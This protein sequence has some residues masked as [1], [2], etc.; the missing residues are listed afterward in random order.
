MFFIT[1]FLIQSVVAQELEK[2]LLWKI[3]RND[4][5]TKES[6]LYGTMHI[7]CDT[8]FT[9]STYNALRA[10]NYLYLEIADDQEN[11][12]KNMMR[13]F[14]SCIMKDDKKLSS[15]LDKADYKILDSLVQDK[16]N[17][18]VSFLDKM[19]PAV[20]SVILEG[21]DEFID[22]PYSVETVLTNIANSQNKEVLGLET[23]D[24]Q[25]NFFI[26]IP[27]DEQ[28]KSLESFIHQ[29]GT[30]EDVDLNAIYKAQDVEQMAKLTYE[31]S[32]GYVENLLIKRN[33]NWLTKIKE[34]TNTSS[35]FFAVGAAHLGGEYGLIALLRKEGYTVEPVF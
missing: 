9:Q 26:S 30:F 1:V 27:I 4:G 20:V 3:S 31:M 22:C 24:E 35:I 21:V 12:E 10:T 11:V 23:I 8:L 19:Y 6:Y 29:D 7:T 34:L 33:S 14:A 13:I 16:L 32:L 2:T 25:M 28:V 15:L 5:I 17:I 18:P